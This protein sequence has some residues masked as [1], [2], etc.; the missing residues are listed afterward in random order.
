M[1]SRVGMA[2]CR[3][4]G[5]GWRCLEDLGRQR[6]RA[7]FLRRRMLRRRGDAADCGERRT[8]ALHRGRA[9]ELLALD[10]G[11][12][13]GQSRASRQRHRRAAAVYRVHCVS[14]IARGVPGRDPS[15]GPLPRPPTRRGG[16]AGRSRGGCVQ[17]HRR[18]RGCIIASA[19][20]A[21]PRRRPRL[22]ETPIWIPYGFHTGSIRPECSLFRRL[23]TFARR[24][25]LQLQFNGRSQIGCAQTGRSPMMRKR[26]GAALCGEA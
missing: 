22:P 20:G 10:G 14:S 2:A 17:P 24:D 3:R 18:H 11:A 12:D 19:T 6:A 21:L 4:R 7:G 25:R 1:C 13:R 5:A 16:S 23:V 15:G 9:G 26:D 8:G